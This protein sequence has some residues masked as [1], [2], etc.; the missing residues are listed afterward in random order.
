MLRRI[1]KVFGYTLI[2]LGLV[3]FI[4]GYFKEKILEKEEKMLI[5][6]FYNQQDEDIEINKDIKSNLVDSNNMKYIAILKIPKIKLEKGL[7]NKDSP[8]NNVN[9]NIEILKESTYPDQ[10]KGNFIL[11]GH[12]G[13]S[14]V[15]YFNDLDKLVIGDVIYI[16][17]KNKEYKYVVNNIY[18]IEKT[19]KAE[20]IRDMSKAC[21]TL[22]TCR[23]NT[24]KQIVIVAELD[25]IKEQND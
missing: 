15:A 10:E 1:F 18:D 14:K 17:Y 13:S 12:S 4:K 16:I 21:L 9:K 23:R 8:Y 5:N 22:I 25:S 11:A 7:F 6:D 2:I 3:L 20:I 19:G 24:N